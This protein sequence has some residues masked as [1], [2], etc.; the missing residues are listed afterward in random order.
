L[1]KVLHVA[2]DPG[3]A[4]DQGHHGIVA[5][6]GDAL[7]DGV[8]LPGPV[9]GDLAAALSSQRHFGVRFWGE[10][11]GTGD[12]DDDDGQSEQAHQKW[13]RYG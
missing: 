7:H 8:Y 6:P 2:G 13:G 5:G 1:Q 9:L 10:S 12:R 4:P 3:P 11:S